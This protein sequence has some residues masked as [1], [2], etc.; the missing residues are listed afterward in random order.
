VPAPLAVPTPAPPSGA[1]RVVPP[2]STLEPPIGDEQT[3]RLT[4]RSS[5]AANSATVTVRLPANATLYV[6]DEVCPLTS[7]VRSFTTTSL[8]P[9]RQ[10]YYMLRAEVVR[11]GQTHVQTARVQFEAGRQVVVNF[12]DAVR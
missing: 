1:P 8:E 11:D 9:G 6:D 3:V 7:S 12:T 10:Y 4:A 2:P 5:P